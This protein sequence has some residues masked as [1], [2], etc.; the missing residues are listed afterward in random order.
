[1]VTAS[2][3]SAFTSAVTC[4]VTK[5]GGTQ[6]ASANSVTHEGNGFHTYPP[7]Q[8][9]TNADHIG[10]TFTGTG[11][12]PQSVQVYPRALT[13][14]VNV[15]QIST[16]STAADN[17]ESFFDGTGY[18]GTGNV[19]PTVSSVTALGTQAKAD[20]NAEVVDVITVDVLGDSV[21][22]DG[23]RPTVGQALLMVTRFLMEASAS[24]TTLTVKK[25]NGSTT[26]MTFTLNDATTPTAITR[27]S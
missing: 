15:A 11:A 5:D 14:D 7:S 22:A 4:L 10:F 8:A 21:A 6:V 24:G 12:V 26:S 2:D 25:E 1:M 19:I 17:A 18:A 13:P 16:D 9:E 27:A 20:V 3:G 23:S